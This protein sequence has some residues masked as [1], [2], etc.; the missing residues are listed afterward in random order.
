MNDLISL[1]PH[2]KK[3]NKLD[4]KNDRAVI[5][6]VADMKVGGGRWVGGCRRPSRRAAPTLLRARHQRCH[7]LCIT[8]ATHAVATP[9]PRPI[10][11]ARLLAPAVLQQ[12]RVF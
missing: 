6:E 3:D 5:N 8:H 7:A 4:T 10:G 1:L 12:R 2:S 9:S 11:P